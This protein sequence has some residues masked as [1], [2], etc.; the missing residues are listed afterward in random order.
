MKSTLLLVFL[1][2]IFTKS[3]AQD[4]SIVLGRYEQFCTAQGKLIKT[5]VIGIGDTRSA[6][7][8]V[9]KTTDVR[10]GDSIS[11]VRISPFFLGVK[12]LI[13]NNNIYIEKDELA[14]VIALLQYYSNELKN[15][16]A[17]Q[18][19]YSYITTNDV[20]I[21]VNYK[22]ELFSTSWLSFS[23]LYQHF[24]TPVQEV[25]WFGRK[26]VAILLNLFQVAQKQM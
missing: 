6:T 12:P 4:S 7:V 13:A 18:F 19:I 9:L 11:V 3:K 10:Q 5:K 24:R 26:D 21:G 14:T 20:R 2:V 8:E 22:E 17:R 25:L 1:S 23:K 15:E 16:N